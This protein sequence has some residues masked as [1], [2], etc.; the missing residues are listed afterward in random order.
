MFEG[1][2]GKIMMLSQGYVPSTCTLTDELAGPLIYSEVAA[3]RDPCAGCNHD[4]SVCHGRPHSLSS[5]LLL[6]DDEDLF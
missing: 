5:P 4:R 1:R 2:A 6:P 3:G